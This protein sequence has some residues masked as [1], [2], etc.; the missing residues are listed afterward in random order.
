MGLQREVM[1][2]EPEQVSKLDEVQQKFGFGNH[3]E[4]TRFLIDAAD[5]DAI[6][7]AAELKVWEKLLED[8]VEEANRAVDRA[9]A[10]LDQAISYFARLN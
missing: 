6:D 8:A 9:E 5:V 3:S 2:L 1:Y 10:S 7:A 4:A